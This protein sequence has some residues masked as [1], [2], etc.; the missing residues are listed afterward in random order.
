MGRAED[1]VKQ[2]R[3]AAPPDATGGSNF[4]EETI[5][6]ENSRRTCGQRGVDLDATNTMNVNVQRILN[7]LRHSIR[8][9]PGKAPAVESGLKPHR[10]RLQAY[11]VGR[12]IEIGPLHNPMPVDAR[13]ASVQYVDRLSL[14]EQRR[15]YPE[16]DAYA[17]VNP[18]MVAEADQLHALPDGSQ[19][20]VIANHVLE[21]LSDPIGA[22]KEWHRVL[23]SEGVLFLALPD[24][25][26]TF[27][28]DRPRT[29]LGHLIADH[30]DRGA[31]SRHDHYVEYSRLL[32]NK[33]GDELE[34]D[35]ANLMA[36]D[37]S[38]HLHVWISEDIAESLDYARNVIGL[39]WTIL[40]QAEITDS[41]EF[42]YVLQKQSLTE[43][44][45]AR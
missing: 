21:H 44:L 24:K 9:A 42:I 26:R 7:R 5:S 25:R 34:N 6:C 3:A 2:E 30:R 45:F 41:D 20:F 22:L 38:I 15:H 23:R 31:A 36:S 37:D 12:G 4:S 40:E 8:T 43:P 33:S 35:V 16:L 28:R 13:R 32:H 14:E 27:D 11:I 19:D 18:D 10:Q 29:T 1:T 17:L 39:C